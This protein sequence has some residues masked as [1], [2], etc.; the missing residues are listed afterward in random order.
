MGGDTKYVSLKRLLVLVRPDLV[1][2]QETMVTTKK[3]R[4]VLARLFPGWECCSSDVVG[5]SGGLFCA[6]NKCVF[7]L[8]P[9]LVDAGVLLEGTCKEDL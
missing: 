6:L 8:A 5:H 2:F 4:R 1:L 7:D 9:F 3:S